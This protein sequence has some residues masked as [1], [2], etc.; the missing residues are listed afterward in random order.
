MNIE[1][2]ITNYGLTTISERFNAVYNTDGCIGCAQSHLAILKLAKERGYKNVLILE[3]DF[4]FLVSKERMEAEL[5]Q[6]FENRIEYDVCFLGYNLIK[7]EDMPSYPFIKRA[8]DVQTSSAYIVNNH[9]YD[10]LIDL[11]EWA[12]PELIRTKQ[13]WNYAYDQAWKKYQVTD[14]WFFFTE[15]IG[16]QRDGVSCISNQYIKDSHY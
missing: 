15:R 16:K 10:K 1:S 13:H 4:Y 9:Y 5:T 14:K 12:I 3:D 7:S 2:E 6:F 11:Y 8:V